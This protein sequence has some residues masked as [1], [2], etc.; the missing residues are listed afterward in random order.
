KVQSNSSIELVA[1]NKY[2]LKNDFNER[3]LVFTDN[4]KRSRN[5]SLELELFGSRVGRM[6]TPCQ[7]Q[8][9]AIFNFRREL[10]LPTTSNNLN[11]TILG[12]NSSVCNCP[13]DG[14]M[15]NKDPDKSGSEGLSRSEE[16]TSS[17]RLSG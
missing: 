3:A 1:L 16:R 10:I 4:D 14:R 17:L 15:D 2:S 11:V 5:F 7:I 6:S 12:H 9:P 13:S 8:V